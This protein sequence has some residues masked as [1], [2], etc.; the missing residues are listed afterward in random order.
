MFKNFRRVKI[1]HFKDTKILY[2]CI[3]PN[4]PLLI[5]SN[6]LFFS[7]FL[8]LFIFNILN[9]TASFLEMRSKLML[10]KTSKNANNTFLNIGLKR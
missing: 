7:T 10:P 4:S 9:Q 5:K 1:V 8:V 3:K 6:L 2:R